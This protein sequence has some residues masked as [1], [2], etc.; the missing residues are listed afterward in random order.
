MNPTIKKNVRTM[1]IIDRFSI[2]DRRLFHSLEAD[3]ISEALRST[4]RDTT[5]MMLIS[6]TPIVE[7][8]LIAEEVALK[9]LVVLS[10]LLTVLN[11][12]DNIC[13]ASPIPYL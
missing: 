4:I 6:D 1:G 8:M 3:R 13:F 11:M 12:D 7:N 5:V 2:V 9:V 10:V